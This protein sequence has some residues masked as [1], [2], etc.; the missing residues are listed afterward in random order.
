MGR[1]LVVCVVAQLFELV[2]GAGCSQSVVTKPAGRLVRP[3]PSI[4]TTN[5]SPFLPTLQSRF[6][7]VLRLIDPFLQN[8]S[9]LSPIAHHEARHQC[10]ERMV[11]VMTSSPLSLAPDPRLNRPILTLSGP[12]HSTVVSGF[13]IVILSVVASLY[14]TNHEEFMGS[15]DDPEDGKAVAGTIFTAVIV[16]AVMLSAPFPAPT[17]T[18]S[19]AELCAEVE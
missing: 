10:Y 4:S 8:I 19:F 3:S 14:R 17:V 7:S 11:M 5:L 15:V 6:S 9:A 1:E 12:H 13:A 2:A 16:Y 18:D